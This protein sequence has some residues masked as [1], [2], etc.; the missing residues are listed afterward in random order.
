[1]VNINSNEPLSDSYSVLVNKSCCSYNDI[2]NPYIKLCVPDGIKNMNIKAF[3]LNSKTNGMISVSC[4]RLVSVN[5][6]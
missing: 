6:D 2:N 5:K 1:M 3:N 4:M